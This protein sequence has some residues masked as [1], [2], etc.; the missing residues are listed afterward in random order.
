M[1]LYTLRKNNNWEQTNNAYFN[2]TYEYIFHLLNEHEGKGGKSN[3]IYEFNQDNYSTKIFEIQSH[4]LCTVAFCEQVNNIT[5]ARR[6][7][8]Y[9]TK[10][11]LD[12]DYGI[13]VSL[14]NFD[15]KEAMKLCPRH[16]NRY[17]L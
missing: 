1:S 11:N 16:I 10:W 2:P 8:V 6:F 14:S 7:L 17:F 13:G 3:K 4:R 12:S 5:G 9:G 15:C